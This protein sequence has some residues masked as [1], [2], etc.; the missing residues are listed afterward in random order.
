MRTIKE[1]MFFFLAEELRKEKAI[2]VDYQIIDDLLLLE[3]QREK[4]KKGEK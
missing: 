3:D 1:K 4:H 2:E